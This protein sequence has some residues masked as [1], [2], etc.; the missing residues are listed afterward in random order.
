MAH[1]P[2]TS[3][4]EHGDTL[5]IIVW[6]GKSSP[7]FCKVVIY[8]RAPSMVSRLGDILQLMVV[9]LTGGG[10]IPKQRKVILR[11][12]ALEGGIRTCCYSFSGLKLFSLCSCCRFVYILHLFPVTFCLTAVSHLKSLGILI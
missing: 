8:K 10:A 6:I 2:E 4:Q 7:H 5:E 12:F 11:F 1:V 3:S 9:K